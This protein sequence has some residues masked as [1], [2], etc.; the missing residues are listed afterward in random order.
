MAKQVGFSAWLY[1]VGFFGAILLGLLEGLGI[2]TLV[3]TIWIPWLLV[4][5]GA[6]I[7]LFNVTTAEAPNTILYALALGAG[8]GII[9]LVP[10]VGGV[11]D[12]VLNKVAFL[13]LAVVIPPAIKGLWKTLN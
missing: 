11:F 4:I 5:I 2:D 1:I 3:N 9:S 7:G 13:S 6:L 8:A 10:G 12:A